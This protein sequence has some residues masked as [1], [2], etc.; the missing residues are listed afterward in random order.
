MSNPYKSMYTYGQH[1]Q[2]DAYAIACD[3][4]NEISAKE[5]LRAFY[6]LNI[7][8]L[9]SLDW[10]QESISNYIK[11]SNSQRGAFHRKLEK[12]LKSGNWEKDEIER[13]SIVIPILAIISLNNIK[14]AFDVRDDYCIGV[15][16]SSGNRITCE[17]MNDIIFELA[18][19]HKNRD[20]PIDT[21]REAAEHWEYSDDFNKL[22]ELHNKL[23][24]DNEK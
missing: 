6:T 11:R 22:D 4:L 8:T 2:N 3:L 21:F 15:I 24:K 19:I 14:M 10:M 18:E 1:A 17:A 5:I 7:D 12:E 20:F 13:I 23:L 16:P 9:Y